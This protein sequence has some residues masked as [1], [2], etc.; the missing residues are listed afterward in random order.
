[1]RH[2]L[3]RIYTEE[4]EDGIEILVGADCIVKVKEGIG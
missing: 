1:M 2:Y 4:E 3:Y